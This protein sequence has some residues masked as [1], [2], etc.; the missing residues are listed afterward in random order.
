MFVF[1]CLDS[2]VGKTVCL[3]LKTSYIPLPRGFKSC[4][5][6]ASKKYCGGKNVPMKIPAECMSGLTVPARLRWFHRVFPGQ[7]RTTLAYLRLKT[8]V[9]N[10]SLEAEL[11]G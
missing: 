3:C 8:V 7:P 6:H 10:A 11:L 9:Q 1:G 2:S 5:Q 4:W